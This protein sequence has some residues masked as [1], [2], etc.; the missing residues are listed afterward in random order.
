MRA[1][2]EHGMPRKQRFK[3][4]RKPKPRIEAAQH[5]QPDRAASAMDAAGL[6]PGPRETEQ[7]EIHPDDVESEGRDA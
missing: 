7:S 5:P 4:S 1:T 3:P 6:E 2:Q